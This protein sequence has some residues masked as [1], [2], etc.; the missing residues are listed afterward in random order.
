MRLE[1]SGKESS[2]RRRF[3]VALIFVL[4]SAVVSVSGCAS[5]RPRYPAEEAQVEVRPPRYAAEPLD[6]DFLQTD[7]ERR[8]AVDQWSRNLEWHGRMLGVDVGPQ[9]SMTVDP[10]EQHV[11]PEMEEAPEPVERV[12]QPAPQSV[13]DRRERRRSR[14][15]I[16]RQAY[17]HKEAICR[18]A[19]RICRIADDLNESEAHERCEWARNECRK[20]E[21]AYRKRC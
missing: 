21:D 12:Y 1:L 15:E 4:L 9:P 20:A 16:C 7:E 5:A 14:R 8:N 13:E 18:A 6:R 2:G 17:L 11:A 10:R 19:E 3:E